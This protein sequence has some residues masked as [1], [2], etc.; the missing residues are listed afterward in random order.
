M[1]SSEC[2]HY[3]CSVSLAV[4]MTSN[5][6]YAVRDRVCIFCMRTQ[7]IEILSIDTKVNDLVTLTVT[8]I[9]KNGKF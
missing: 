9:L 3:F 6:D 5:Y 4:T 2:C 8:F 7:L 1:H